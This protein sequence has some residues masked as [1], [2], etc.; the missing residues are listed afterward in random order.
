LTIERVAIRRQQIHAI[1]RNDQ[2]F[3]ENEQETFNAPMAQTM[4]PGSVS[5]AA[6]QSEPSAQGLRVRGR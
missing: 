6:A 1:I 3:G 4:P 2:A 5:P